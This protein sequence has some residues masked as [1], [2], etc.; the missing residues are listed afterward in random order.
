[1]SVVQLALQGG[2]QRRQPTGG[3]FPGVVVGDLPELPQPGH[4]GFQLADRAGEV[5]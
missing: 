5:G 3:E 1:M 2:E 4:V